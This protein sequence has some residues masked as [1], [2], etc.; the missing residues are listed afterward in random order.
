MYESAEAQ[1]PKSR[2]TG[3]RPVDASVAAWFPAPGNSAPTAIAYST[4]G[5]SLTYLNPEPGTST[6][7]YWRVDLAGEKPR[8]VARPPDEGETDANVSQAEALRRERMR[9]RDTGI[10]QVA[11]SDH[12]DA[13]VTT[14]SGEIYRLED[15]K[16][17]LRLT[18][19]SSPAIDPKPSPD[20]SKVAFVRDGQL[21]VLDLAIGADLQLT[22]HSRRET[23]NGLAEFI[24]QE[25][26]GRFTGFWWSPDSS[27]IAYQESDESH[28]PT[29]EIQSQGGKSWS[30]ESHRYPFAG[31][32]NARVRLGLISVK[33]GEPKWLTLSEQEAEV[34]LARVHW[35]SPSSVLVV[36]LARDQKTLTLSRFEVSTVSRTRLLE[37]KAQT[38]VNLHDDLRTLDKTGEF[39]WSSERTGSRQLELHDRDGRLVRVLTSGDRPIDSVLA[40]DQARREVW[41]AAGLDNPCEAHVYRVSLDGGKVERV[42]RQRGTHKAVVASDGNSYVDTFSSRNTPPITT[43]LDRSGKVLATLDDAGNDPRL[44]D[45]RLVPPVL[46]QFKNRDGLTL[47]GAYY[48]PRSG[49]SGEKAPLV[50]MVYGGPHVQTVTDSWAV[51]ADLTAQFLAERGLAVWK[52]DNRGS[53]RRGHP[54]EAA[55]N[56]NMGSVEVRDQVDGVRFAAASW[57]E[58]DASRVGVTGRSY[59]GYMTLRCLTE[60][61]EVFKAGVSVAPVTDWDGYDTCYTERYMGTP[62]NNPEGYKAA[63]VLTRVD[64]LEGALL[65]VHGMLD[66]NV[67]FRHAARLI[68]AL[69]EAGKDFEA[70][71]L[72]DSRHGTRK[73]IDRRYLNER[74]ARFFAKNLAPSSSD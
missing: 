52:A 58:V 68:N 28:I 54:F 61:P 19:G 17:P 71:P 21:H 56:R 6:R 9:L 49:K 36:T 69:I 72:P 16:P 26:M 66:E 31:E 24:A 37:E 73:E 33:G 63:S 23:T 29:Y 3:K 70:L 11:R 50:V 74:M 60:A 62:Q 20:G 51:T 14:L 34:Y 42:T 65:V 41:F 45:I 27:T 30:K 5:K 40:V 46:T 4:D 2:L 57:P 59:G 18:H 67:H 44:A 15:D 25:E 8:I 43:L 53:S 12:A 32:P 55:L 39:V 22:H 47:H 64:R 10:T 7:V 35:E 38:W 13:T 1:Q 48:A